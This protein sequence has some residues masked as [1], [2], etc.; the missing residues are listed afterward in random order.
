MKIKNDNVQ[1]DSGEAEVVSGSYSA[2][3]D[4]RRRGKPIAQC[5]REYVALAVK[6][7]LSG[8]FMSELELRRYLNKEAKITLEDSYV[9]GVVILGEYEAETYTLQLAENNFSTCIMDILTGK[10][11]KDR[12][13]KL[14][15]R[16]DKGAKMDKNSNFF[17]I[18]DAGEDLELVRQYD[19]E[20]VIYKGRGP[21]DKNDQIVLEKDVIDFIKHGGRVRAKGKGISATVYGIGSS[22]KRAGKIMGLVSVEVETNKRTLIIGEDA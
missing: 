10:S 14:L 1:V 3:L 5:Y 19:D 4:A 18:T 6:L 22:S 7:G 2:L 17:F 11:K 16:F 9:L 15:S 13:A 8:P 20:N 21:S 12:D